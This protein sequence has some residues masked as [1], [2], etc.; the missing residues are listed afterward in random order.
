MSR[1]GNR[2]SILFGALG[3]LAVAALFL[4]GCAGGYVDPGPSPAKLRVQLKAEAKQR[5]S[6]WRRGA[7]PV[8]WDW[9]LYLVR[10]DK[11]LARLK[12]ADG[13]RLTAIQENPLLRDTV[14][15]L[16]PGR[17][18]VRIILEAYY[19]M[20]HAEGFIP[21]SLGGTV[22]DFSVEAVQGAEKNLKFTYPE[23]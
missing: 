13:Q 18:T 23:Q 2:R 22:R 16:P 5:P 15:L 17:H 9:G 11:R 4:S 14:F 20:P 8:K 7:Y 12:T 10:D 3:L 1:W 21:V 6:S 19:Y